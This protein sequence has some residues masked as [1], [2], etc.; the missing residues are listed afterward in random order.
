MAKRGFSVPVFIQYS[1]DL[2]FLDHGE[3]EVSLPNLQ[4]FFARLRQY[5]LKKRTNLGATLLESLKTGGREHLFR[6]LDYTEASGQEFPNTLQEYVDRRNDE[7]VGDLPTYIDVSESQK[8]SDV[9]G[10]Q[11]GNP[12]SQMRSDIIRVIRSPWG[13]ALK[14]LELVDTRIQSISWVAVSSPKRLSSPEQ[15]LRALM[16]YS[17]KR[18]V[19]KLRFLKNIPLRMSTCSGCLR[20]SVHWVAFRMN[21]MILKL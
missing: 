4:E 17:G 5:V 20:T 8:L 1:D 3:V 18:S 13:H 6:L 14:T 10:E 11:G 16:L 15:F 9:S 21:S 2:L 12:T 7:G 19:A